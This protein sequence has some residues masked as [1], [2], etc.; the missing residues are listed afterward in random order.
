MAREYTNRA[1]RLPWA[2]ALIAALGLAACDID[3]MLEVN[4]PD[5]ATPGM[6]EGPDALPVRLT[7]QRRRSANSGMRRVVLRW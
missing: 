2:A 5:V 6:I 3:E 1:G 7:A 4:D